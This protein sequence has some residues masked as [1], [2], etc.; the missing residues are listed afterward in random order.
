MNNKLLQQL[1]ESLNSTEP[2]VMVMEV[3]HDPDCPKLYG[4]PCT[5]HPTYTAKEV[6]KND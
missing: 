1:L 5:C 2:K 6:T 3:A 4:K